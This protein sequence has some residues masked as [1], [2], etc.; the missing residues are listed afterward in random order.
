MSPASSGLVTIGHP[1]SEPLRQRL[2]EGGGVHARRLEDML[3]HIVLERL[4]AD[5]LNDV[6]GQGHA[7]IGVGRSS[8]GG[9]DLRRGIL[10]DGLIQ[11]EW[12]GLRRDE[13]PASFLESR[14]VR[15]EV[16]QGD[17]T[18][19]TARDL[20]IG[21]GADINVQV[22]LAP[23]HQLHH[24]DTGGELGHRCDAEEGIGIHRAPRLAVGSRSRIPVPPRHQDPT[25]VNDGDH[26]SGKVAPIE[27]VGDL[28]IEPGSDI[29]RGQLMPPLG[30]RHMRTRPNG[31]GR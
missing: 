22:Q 12:P 13:I 5:P 15:Q 6:T 14:G 3:A 31:P 28:P 25:I 2:V 11:V 8:T 21:V 16:P 4:A 24:R 29:L 1:A 7:V 9:E 20:H 19:I 26:R 30:L 10:P 27:G 17:I 23:L 18:G